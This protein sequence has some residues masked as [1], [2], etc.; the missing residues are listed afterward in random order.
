MPG[1]NNVPEELKDQIIH[2]RITIAGTVVMA[3]DAP[4][5]VWQPMRS[6]YLALNV[7]SSEEAERI[8]AVLTEGSEIFMKLDET[9]FAH[10]FAMLRDR[11]GISWML[12]HE[13]PMP[14]QR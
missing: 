2:A 1:A 12:I 7:D 8:Y 6:A 3:S 9:F 14:P 13:K 5:E 11:F 4:R 10:R